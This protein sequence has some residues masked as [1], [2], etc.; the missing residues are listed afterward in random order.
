MNDMRDPLYPRDN[1]NTPVDP[2]VRSSDS[3]RWG[4]ILGGLA[5]LAIV[6]VFLFGMGG[7]DRTASTQNPSAVVTGQSNT[8]AAPA[9]PAEN[10]GAST[11]R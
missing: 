9:A 6:M 10:T 8:P 11:T 4:W 1:L 7:D 2:V 3:P 5:A